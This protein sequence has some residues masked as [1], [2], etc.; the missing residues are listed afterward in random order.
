MKIYSKLD[1]LTKLEIQW[2]FRDLK[3]FSATLATASDRCVDGWKYRGR[4][5]GAKSPHINLVRMVQTGPANIFLFLPPFLPFFFSP[6]REARVQVIFYFKNK[7]RER[8]RE[9]ERVR[10]MRLPRESRRQSVG[11]GRHSLD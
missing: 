9:R 8:E 5:P 4:D 6:N 7:Q 1:S 3:E 2:R 11:R 10:E